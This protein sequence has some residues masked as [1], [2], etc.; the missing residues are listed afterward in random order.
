MLETKSKGGRPPVGAVP[1]TVRLPPDLLHPLDAW[2]AQQPDPKPS[3]PEAIRRL[4]DQAL[5]QK[6]G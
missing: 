4:V 6:P 1:V 2:I 3:R 5:A